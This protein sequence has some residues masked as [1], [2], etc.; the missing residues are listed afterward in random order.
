M[1]LMVSLY[2]YHLYFLVF[3]CGLRS[4]GSDWIKGF[5]GGGK[6]VELQLKKT[7]RLH[8]TKHLLVFGKKLKHRSKKK[9]VLFFLPIFGFFNALLTK[10]ARGVNSNLY[11]FIVLEI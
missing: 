8:I 1:F 2:T 4:C 9:S 3:H 5:Y 6:L 11:L 10:N 7:R